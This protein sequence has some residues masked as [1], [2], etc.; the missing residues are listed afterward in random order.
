MTGNWNVLL[1][2]LFVS[3]NVCKVAEV[4]CNDPIIFSIA[5]VSVI[6][7][8]LNAFLRSPRCNLILVILSTTT[9]TNSDSTFS[10]VVTL[11]CATES[12]LSSR[13]LASPASISLHTPSIFWISVFTLRTDSDDNFALKFSI[14]TNNKLI[15]W[16]NVLRSYLSRMKWA[17][18]IL[19]RSLYLVV[20]YKYTP[21]IETNQERGIRNILFIMKNKKYPFCYLQWVFYM[22]WCKLL[23]IKE[24]K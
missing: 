19:S 22:F 5:V 1:K 4:S 3:K 10:A 18:I 11:Y 23:A 13:Q 17:F 24:T 15:K 20:Y 7:F 14:I 6:T 9:F 16:W 12:P 8:W 21:E 2:K